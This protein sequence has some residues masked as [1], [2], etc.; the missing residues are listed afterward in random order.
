LTHK[1]AT[2]WKVKAGKAIPL[3]WRLTDA[4]GAP[5]PTLGS[6]Q[7]SVV[8]I[9][10]SSGTTLDQIE[11]VAAGV[12]GLQNLGEGYYQLN[13]KSPAGYANSCKRLRL[14]LSEGTA[15][16]PVYHTADFRFTK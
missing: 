1:A 13:W 3:K 7:I 14:N 6:A 9:S 10:C 12:S 5:V 8:G 11:E 15:A 16:N 4:T 2:P